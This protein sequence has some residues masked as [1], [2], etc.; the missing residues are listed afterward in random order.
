[1]AREEPSAHK[2]I[3]LAPQSRIVSLGGVVPVSRPFSAG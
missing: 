2:P 1:M 3:P